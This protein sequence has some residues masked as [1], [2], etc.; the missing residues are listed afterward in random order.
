[1]QGV[2]GRGVGH[3]RTQQHVVQHRTTGLHTHEREGGTRNMSEERLKGVEGT[4]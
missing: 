4:G 1:V 3:T 2:V